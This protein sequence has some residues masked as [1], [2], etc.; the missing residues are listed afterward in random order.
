MTP[1]P[2]LAAGEPHPNL[3]QG[4]RDEQCV[5]PGRDRTFTTGNYD[6]TTTPK[7]ELDIATGQM[8]C[9]EE[10]RKDTKGETVRVTRRPEELVMHPLAVRAKLVRIEVI[11]LVSR[12]ACFQPQSAAVC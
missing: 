6:L 9:P 3:E 7:K 12:A 11:A 5:L 1:T 10:D 2:P 4:M 8:E